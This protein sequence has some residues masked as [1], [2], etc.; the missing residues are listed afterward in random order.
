MRPTGPR[1]D[2]T[3]EALCIACIGT[4]KKCFLFPLLNSLLETIKK[5]IY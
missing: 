4:R 3:L 2:A 5:I 1:F